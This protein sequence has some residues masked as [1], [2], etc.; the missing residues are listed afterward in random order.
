MNRSIPEVAGRGAL[1]WAVSVA[2]GGAKSALATAISPCCSYPSRAALPSHPAPQPT[3][4]C[5]PHFGQG[6]MR[7]E[8]SVVGLAL[9]VHYPAPGTG[10]SSFSVL[11]HF[12]V[13]LQRR[14]YYYPHFTDGERALASSW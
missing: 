12:P 7:G 6:Q 3:D 11:T 8:G 1:A 9:T 14:H 13:T 10:L 5:S 2:E 4:V